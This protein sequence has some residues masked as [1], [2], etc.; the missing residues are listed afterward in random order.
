MRN[1]KIPP[2][3]RGKEILHAFLILGRFDHRV[4][5]HGWVHPEHIKYF[6]TAARN[7]SASAFRIQLAPCF[8]CI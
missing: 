5:K 6:L 4:L 8:Y 7:F 2:G 3:L 1:H